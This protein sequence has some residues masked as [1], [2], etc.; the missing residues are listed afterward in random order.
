VLAGALVA[1]VVLGAIGSGALNVP[2]PTQTT[3]ATVIVASP[4][5]VPGSVEACAP[6]ALSAEITAWEGA[7]GHR[8]AN[9]KLRNTGAKACEVPKLLRPVLI[10]QAG[11]ALILGTP[12]QAVE[13]IAIAAST[14]ATT[15]VDMT[16]YCGA[17]PTSPLGIRL[18]LTTDTSVEAYPA[19]GV[20]LPIDP[21]PCNGPN[22]AA[23]IEMQPLQL[24]AAGQ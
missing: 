13:A 12:P 7:A 23:S 17:D 14:S 3:A 10:E 5:S 1:A 16:N 18:Y 19:G 6:E 9:V 22:Q 20:P 11:N 21:P 24:T 15:F 2:G 8:I 4:T